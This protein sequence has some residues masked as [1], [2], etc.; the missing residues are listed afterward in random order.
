M[1]IAV[2]SITENGR[3][4][5]EKIT[6]QLKKH[7]IIRFCFNKH[8]DESAES[9][10]N[11][12]ILTKKLMPIYDALIFVCACGI[13]VRSIAP[14]IDSKQTDPAVI[15]IDDSGKFV[16]PILSGHIG[17]ANKL[18]K[19]IAKKIGAQPVITTATDVGGKFSPDSFAAAN[20]LIIT[21]M[22]AAKAVAAAALD[23]KKIGLVCPYEYNDLPAELTVDETP[24]TGIVIG[25]AES[26]FE[27]T[28]RLLPKNI[29]LGVGCRKNVPKDIFE[30]AV[31]DAM[32]SAGILMEQVKAVA[33]I[34]IKAREGAVKAFCQK[35]GLRLYIYYA[36]A[37]MSLKGDFTASD[38]VKEITGV[39][40]VCERSAVICS[41]GELVLKKTAG[42]S[43]T[44]AAAEIPIEL[45]FEKEE[46]L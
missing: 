34:D 18:A 8:T 36:D 37:L 17:G 24:E 26:P 45:D 39:D 40:N 6:K 11:L 42:N 46:I 29:V 35:Y 12:E 25:M 33:T 30:N 31:L 15:V 13:A 20:D 23:G 1:K 4:L 28:L 21:D 16:I 3:L 9:F 32:E 27:T 14:Y 41:G 43:T 44:V 7:N 2:I 10:D 19:E 5:S 38:F 22:S